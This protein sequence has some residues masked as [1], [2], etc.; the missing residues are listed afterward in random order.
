MAMNKNWL[1]LLPSILITIFLWN[2]YAFTK[3]ECICSWNEWGFAVATI[4]SIIVFLIQGISI[5]ILIKNQSKKICAYYSLSIVV[6]VVVYIVIMR[7]S[8]SILT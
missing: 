8:L 6:S 4:A 5:F 3:V 1:L 2:I 7:I